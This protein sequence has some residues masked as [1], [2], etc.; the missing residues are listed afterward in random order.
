[1]TEDEDHV[2]MT[3]DEY[4]AKSQNIG[5]RITIIRE[6]IDAHVIDHGRDAGSPLVRPLLD[7]QEQLFGELAALDAKFWGTE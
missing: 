7:R 5:K 4:Q 6:Q 2:T 3:D 1:M